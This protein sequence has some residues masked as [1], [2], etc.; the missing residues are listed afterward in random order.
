MA[1]LR[2]TTR[3]GGEAVLDK[4]AVDK[5]RAGLRG[6]MVTPGDAAYDETRTIWNAIIDR[7][8]ALIVRCAGVSDVMQ[9]VR[10]AR[11]H[12]LLLAVRGGGHNVAGK[13]VGEG[14]LMIDLSPMSGIRVDPVGRTC[15]VEA[16]ATLADMDHETQTFGL[17]TP[18]GINSTTGVAGLT[19]G[20]GLGWLSRK[21]GLTVDNLIEADIV[22]AEGALVTA[23]ERDHADLFWGIRGGG[24]NFGV[25]TSFQFQLHPVGPQVLSGLI[26]HPLKDAEKLLQ[27]YRS[28]TAQAPDDLACWVVMRQAPPLPFLPAAVHGTEVVV[29]AA[30]YAGD[31]TEG[32]RALQPLR[33]FGSPIADVI[34]PHPYAGFQQAFDPLLT[35]SARN[36]WRSHNFAELPDGLI[37]T[38]ID[39]T[40]RLPGPQCEIFIFN[41]GGAVS[42]VDP[43]ATAYAHRDAPYGLNAHA[44]WN[45]PSQDEACI[46]WARQLSDAAGEFATGGVYV[47]FI[48]E[49]EERVAAAYG[50]NYDRL[51]TLKNKYDPTNLFC[52]NQNIK[53]TI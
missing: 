28:F 45:N 33:A 50:V 2:I 37:S 42:R 30:L 1:G 39:Y 13:S 4:A 18:L 22:T 51:V 27:H 10:L 49:G 24:G 32:E 52:L 11:E 53:P 12:D 25:V 38:L 40:N 21:Y 3:T 7:Q 17:A 36:Y 34:M 20:G 9:S 47:N 46:S 23:N 48:S 43:Q 41:L 44:R 31:M 6:A 15:R 16:G 19:L 14:S 35:P 8:P 29:I 5:F 26:I